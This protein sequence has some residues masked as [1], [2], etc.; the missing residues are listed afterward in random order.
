M[1]GCPLMHA[2]LPRTAEGRAP[3]SNRQGLCGKVSARQASGGI[4]RPRIEKAKI[5]GFSL[6]ARSP[7]EK[8]CWDVRR[9]REEAATVC[10]E[11]EEYGKDGYSDMEEI[12]SVG[13]YA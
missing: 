12:P 10:S 5:E 2:G 7:A 9:V 3:S 11:E 8:V 1:D 13:T 4:L 6:D